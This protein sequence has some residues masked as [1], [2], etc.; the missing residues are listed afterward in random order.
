M[1]LTASLLLRDGRIFHGEDS[2]HGGV[3]V[4]DQIEKVSAKEPA[5]LND[6]RNL[7]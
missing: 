4:G 7:V 6:R 3:L 1:S 5:L 2:M